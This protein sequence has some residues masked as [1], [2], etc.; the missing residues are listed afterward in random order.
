[1]AIANEHHKFHMFDWRMDFT[2]IVTAWLVLQTIFETLRIYGT[3]QDMTQRYMTTESTAK[4]NRS[5]WLAILGYIPLGYAFY[6]IGTGL[7]VFYH[8]HP[9]SVV[10]SLI[11]QKR[12][13]AIYPYFVGTNMPAGAGGLVIAAFFAATMSTVSAVMNSSSTVFVEDFYKRLIGTPD[14][15]LRTQHSALNIARGLT[16]VWGLLATVTALV[17]ATHAGLAQI[18]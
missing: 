9:D 4:A 16:V 10:N 14:S 17:L 7:F 2:Q 8:L 5:V 13:D 15:A 18:A 6:F 11:E 12:I 1:M 3:Q